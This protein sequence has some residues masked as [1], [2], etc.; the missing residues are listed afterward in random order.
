MVNLPLIIVGSLAI[1]IISKFISHGRIKKDE[2]TTRELLLG[3]M[4]SFFILTIAQS[5]APQPVAAR[6][7][8]NAALISS[9]FILVD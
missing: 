4:V 5:V 8:G 9:D 6:S 1:P 7:I 3:T 2:S